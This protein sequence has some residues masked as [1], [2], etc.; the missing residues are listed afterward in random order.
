LATLFII[1]GPNGA[2]KSTNSTAFLEPY[3]LTAFD[4]DKEL[5]Q[6]WSRFGFD[7]AVEDGVRE[8]VGELFLQ[9]KNAA[10][11]NNTDFAFETNYHHDS[12]VQTVNRFKEVGHQAVM[13]F[14]ALPNDESAIARVKRRVSEG[15]HSVDEKTIRERYKKGLQLLDRTFDAYDRVHLYLSEENEV[16]LILTLNPKNNIVH[17]ETIQLMDKLPR[18]NAFVRAIEKK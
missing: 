6:A 18:L 11:Q 9:M 1:G 15:G 5:E 13:I 17:S 12:I 10:I 7:P 14:L 8:S 2:G 3:N 16:K 4:Y